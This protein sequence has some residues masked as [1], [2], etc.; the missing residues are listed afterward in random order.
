MPKRFNFLVLAK[1]SKF[2]K[3]SDKHFFNSKLEHW[4]QQKVES[5]HYQTLSEVVCEALRTQIQREQQRDELRTVIEDGGAEVET[6]K[7]IGLN[8]LK[9]RLK[10]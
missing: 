6:E 5:G 2:T 9:K 8:E 1:N 10:H 4:I 7:T 3:L